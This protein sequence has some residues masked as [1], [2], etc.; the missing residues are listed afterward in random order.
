L[1]CVVL[2][3][4]CGLAAGCGLLAC[5]GLRLRAAC[6]GSPTS[7][8]RLT[9]ASCRTCHAAR[10]VCSWSELRSLCAA[11][12]VSLLAAAG[13]PLVDPVRFPCLG[14]AALI[15]ALWRCLCAS[16]ALGYGIGCGRV[17]N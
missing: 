2:G 10:I 9:A 5:S 1:A 4:G 8:S 14:W 13:R 11:R 3:V 6:Y 7:S 12:P 16:A 17:S 15:W